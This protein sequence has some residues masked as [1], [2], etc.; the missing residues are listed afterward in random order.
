[1]A[2]GISLHVGVNKLRPSASNPD[3]LPLVGCVNDAHAMSRIAMS[4][5]FG[6]VVVLTDEQATYAAVKQVMLDAAAELKS[7]DIFLFSFAGHGTQ[8][9]F[10]HPTPGDTEFIDQT[11]VLHDHIMAD[12]V[13]R[14]AIWPEFEEGVRVLMVA[15]SCHSGTLLEA[16]SLLASVRREETLSISAS[17]VSLTVGVEV[18]ASDFPRARELSAAVTRQ[19]LDEFRDFYE[20]ERESVTGKPVKASV[21]LLAACF[22]FEKAQDGSPHGAFTQALLDVWADGSFSDYETFRDRIRDIVL[23]RVPP[24]KPQHPQ[25]NHLP[26]PNQAF[27]AQ[28]PFTVPSP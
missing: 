9:D 16:V 27:I 14:H 11:I 2:K 23:P 5:G 28:R 12:D 15:D 20:R 21:L 18:A 10:E 22:D 3:P 6:E 19:H 4:S 24:D 8:V 7:G 1:M 25:L 13:L 26:P 17:H